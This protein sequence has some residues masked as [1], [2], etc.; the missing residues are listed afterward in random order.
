MGHFRVPLGLCIKT[1]LSAQPLIWKWFF[2]LMQIKLIFTR[3]V[4]HLASFWK[5]G[6]SFGTCKWPIKAPGGLYLEI[7]LS[8]KYRIEQSKNGT[9]TQFFICQKTGC[10]NQLQ[11]KSVTLNRCLRSSLF[12]LGLDFSFHIK[13]LH[14]WVLVRSTPSRRVLVKTFWKLLT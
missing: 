1:R 4:V 7:A 9:V 11:P 3:K 5:W 13:Y 10:A 12:T 2:I 6:F 8:L 14:G